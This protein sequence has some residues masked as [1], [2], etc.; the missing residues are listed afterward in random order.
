[1]RGRLLVGLLTCL[2]LLV[3]APAGAATSAGPRSID[4]LAT[5]LRAD[6]IVVEPALGTGDAAGV[7][8]VLTKLATEVDAPV[9]IVLASLPPELRAAGNPAEQAGALLH[10]T[11]GDGL[12]V[13][14]FTDGISW[15]GGFGAA[16]AIDFRPGQRAEGRARE[17]GPLEYN[18][19]TAA[20]EAELVLRSAADPGRA[21]SD[22][23]LREWID[24]PRAF[25]PTEARDRVDQVAG[26]W[27]FTIASALAVLIAGLTLVLVGAKYPIGRRRPRQPD[28][29]RPQ[30][31]D[32]TVL[33]RV[34]KRYDALRAQDLASPH[35]VAAAEALEAADLVVG[36]GDRL[37][38]VGA[39]VLAKQAERE[40]DRIKR[41]AQLTYRPCVVN[42]L[43]GEA[44]A[45]VPLAG[46]SIDAPACLSCS[47]GHGAFLTTPT[48]RG[49]RRYLDTSTVWARTGFGALVDDLAQQVIADRRRR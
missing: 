43:H 47:R 20:L 42:P 13:I 7:H 32:D 40:L 19:T 5:A 29:D 9:Y 23:Q 39:W 44:A 17:I 11:L 36:T 6:P 34:Q 33:P 15:V 27:V 28:A 4:Q 16:K 2:T 18:Q 38:Q 25:V 31:V 21:F 14:Q 35:A 24:T 46:S 45:T 30:P 12:Y 8:D 1:M 49:D 26:R 37:D 3:A 22:D 41:T 10:A 48:W